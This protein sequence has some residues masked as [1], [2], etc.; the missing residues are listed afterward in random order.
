M[1]PFTCADLQKHTASR[2]QLDTQI[3]ENNTVQEVS[4]WIKR[5]ASTID[6]RLSM[7]RYTPTNFVPLYLIYHASTNF[8]LVMYVQE[9]E[10][11]EDD[12]VVYK[13][14][15]PVLVKQDVVE[16]RVT[17]KKRLDYITKEM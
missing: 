16:A 12:A 4:T 14:V 15:G 11:L 9:L 7:H 10:L 1:V 6:H 2:M 13:L 17:V 3:N 8:C 5:C